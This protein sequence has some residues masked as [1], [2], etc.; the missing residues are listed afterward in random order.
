MKTKLKNITS[1][2]G[3]FV[4]GNPNNGALGTIV[5][6]EW[7]NGIQ[8]RT[9]DYFEELRNVLLLANTTP[10]PSKTNQIAEAIKSYISSLSASPT[11]KGLVQIADNLTTDDSNKALSAKQGKT[12][13]DEID[14]LE[15][16]G[17]NYLR[18]SANFNHILSNNQGVFPITKTVENGINVLTSTMVDSGSP[19]FGKHYLSTY[20]LTLNNL[21]ILTDNLI[22]QQLTVSVD[23]KSNVNTKIR[24]GYSKYQGAEFDLV[25]GQW[26][27]IH[28]SFDSAQGLKRLPVF[29]NERGEQEGNTVKI[30]HKNWKVEKGNRPSDW[31]PAP[32]DAEDYNRQNYVA[33]SG[34]QMGSLEI[35]Q[36]HKITTSHYGLGL[37]AAQ[38]DS[39]APFLVSQNASVA[40]DTYHPFIKGKVRSLNQWGAALSFGYTTNQR[41][42]GQ[43]G[44][45]RGVVHLAEDN[46]RN[47]VWNFEHDGSF[48]A[49]D[50]ATVAGKRLSNA[51]MAGG[52]AVL[53][54]EIAHGGTLPIPSGFTESQCR[55]FVSMKHSNPN[56]KGWDWNENTG[57]RHYRT[58]CYARGRTV[59]CQTFVNEGIW[60][61]GATPLTID[62]IAN[63]LVIG[64]K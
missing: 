46:G 52:V 59:T 23:V 12:L 63:Y 5:T 8:E 60:G 58:Q 34:D 30:Y 17:R 54:G 56:G 64:V 36:G 19:T 3:K 49:G 6:A 43:E 39:G 14:G 2:T 35:N 40:R 9:Q 20:S 42:D 16:G 18:N 22:D 57:G 37:Y 10:D 48:I 53:T 55:F 44:F 24:L 28:Y 15:V 33:K 45:G 11:Q 27:R 61:G 50:V 51:M 21:T 31:S 7:L 4:D 41:T 38:Y 1:N 47:C 13:K 62:G 32:E 26:Q 25:A 29:Y